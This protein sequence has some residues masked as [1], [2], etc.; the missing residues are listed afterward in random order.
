[1]CVCMCVCIWAHSSDSCSQAICHFNDI[2]SDNCLQLCTASNSPFRIIIT[3][4]QQRQQQREKTRTTARITTRGNIK[5]N[6]K[7]ILLTVRLL[8]RIVSF[9]CQLGNAKAKWEW[10]KP[11]NCM[12]K[13][14]SVQMEG[15]GQ[16]TGE[17]EEAETGQLRKIAVIA[18]VA[19]I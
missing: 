17:E 8:F 15:K 7:L 16:E 13:M 5:S 11:S 9:H 1:M 3:T 12:P 4:Q 14:L 6:Y 19:E 2:A 18:K 10:T